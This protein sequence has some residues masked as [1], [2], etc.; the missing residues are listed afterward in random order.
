MVVHREGIN[1]EF[2]YWRAVVPDDA[3]SRNLI[4]R[5]LHC[6]PFSAHPG[7]N[8][9]VAKVQTHFFWRGMTGHVREFVESCCVCQTE[10]S[11]HTLSKGKLQSVQLPQ[12]KWQ[13]IS[14]DFIT[15]LPLTRNKKDS[16]LTVVDKA[17]R[18]VHLVPC[19]KDVTAADTAR[20]VW[21]HIVKLHGIPRVIFSDRGTQF[22]SHFWQELWKMTGTSL[23]FS[24]SY[25]PQTQGVVERMNSVV[26][27]TFRCLITESEIRDWE[28]LLSTVEI[29]INS[30]PNSSTGY[31][32][33]Y[34]NYGFHPV[35]PIELL[36][37][38]E[39]SVVEAVTNFVERICS[40]W[41]K[42]KENLQKSVVK[43]ARLYDKKHRPVEFAVGDRVLLSTRNLNVKNL[44]AKLKSRFCGPFVVSERIGQQAYRIELPIDWSVHDVFHVSL[45]KPWRAA[46]YQE[47][48]EELNVQLEENE[49]RYEV[50]RILHWRT[51][52]TS[53]NK[54]KKE[55]LVLWSGYPMEEASWI[56]AENFDDQDR[57]QEDLLRDQPTEEK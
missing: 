15:D 18:M 31:T 46:I 30:S 29:T 51:R 44:P 33:F 21:Q 11:D 12:E 7:V 2:D 19:R 23:K 32:P 10:K 41:N 28:Q 34:L 53:R 4:I 52:K 35:A 39:K 45:L 50:E 3:N 22:T 14:L 47:I 38:D 56:P 43:Q 26:S 17:T 37:G 54:S 1:E 40:L 25:H 13:E 49:P 8:R 20:L 9:T 36:A 16:I 5:E 57:L 42:A 48:P 24:T 6:I 27:Q 55:Y